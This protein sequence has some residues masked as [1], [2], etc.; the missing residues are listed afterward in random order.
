MPESP[1]RNIIN[2]MKTNTWI[3]FWNHFKTRFMNSL[4]KKS[5]KFRNFFLNA[6]ESLSLFKAK[7]KRVPKRIYVYITCDEKALPTNSTNFMTNAF[8]TRFLTA[9][10]MFSGFLRWMRNL[11]ASSCKRNV[12]W[13][14]L[15]PKVPL[16]QREDK[17]RD[18]S[19]LYFH[20]QAQ[21]TAYISEGK[22]ATKRFIL[23]SF[24][25]KMAWLIPP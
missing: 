15:S 16:Y 7:A 25:K 11:Y 14:V 10:A 18:I 20:F 6:M 8:V 21:H 12:L 4:Q 22:W 3:T 13:W 23:F 1:T 5:T 24:T 17:D 19:A 9:N 2:T